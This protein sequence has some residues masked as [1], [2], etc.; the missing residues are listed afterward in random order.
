MTCAAS[1]I[2]CDASFHV[3]EGGGR[4][5]GTGMCELGSHSAVESVEFSDSSGIRW[6]IAFGRKYAAGGSGRVVSTVGSV[7]GLAAW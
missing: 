3:Q 2:V 1:G 6:R 7:P 4:R 5:E